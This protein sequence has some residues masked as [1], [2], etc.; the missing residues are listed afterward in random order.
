MFFW[1]FGLGIFY[2]HLIYFVII[3]YIFFHFGMLY[4][5]KSG[6]P[7]PFAAVNFDFRQKCRQR[8]TLVARDCH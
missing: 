8:Q 6:N 2:G 4:Q 3:W 5:E 1:Q 7:A